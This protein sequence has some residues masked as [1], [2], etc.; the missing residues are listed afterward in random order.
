MNRGIQDWMGQGERRWETGTDRQTTWYLPTVHTESHC[1]VVQH[2]SGLPAHGGTIEFSHFPCW[3][4]DQSTSST[5]RSAGRIWSCWLPL[6]QKAI[7]L[8][9]IPGSTTM[10]TGSLN[11][12][13]VCGE[14]TEARLD[15]WE[16]EIHKNNYWSL[17]NRLGMGSS[18][19]QEP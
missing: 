18:R 19:S 6:Q 15:R 10:L 13:C 14:V 4:Q 5:P 3:F 9:N 17:Q 1:E 11:S 7:C 2:C 12:V 16:P 8:L